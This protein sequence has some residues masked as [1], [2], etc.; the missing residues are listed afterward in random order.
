MMEKI[1]KNAVRCK[2]CNEI[3]ESKSV[4]DLVT[5]KCGRCSVDGGRQYIRRIFTT[6]IDEDYEE[7]SEFEK[8]DN[9]KKDLIKL[10]K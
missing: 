2:S 6:S 7:L 1:I 10:N 8:I 5:C 4:H 3:I 9:S